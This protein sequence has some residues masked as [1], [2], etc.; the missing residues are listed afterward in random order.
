MTLH[1][2]AGDTWPRLT[3]QADVDLTM[4]SVKFIMYQADAVLNF[5]EVL[6]RPASVVG[7]PAEGKVEYVWKSADT[8]TPGRYFCVF[9]LTLRD[10][11]VLSLP[12]KG[13]LEVRI[14]E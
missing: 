5:T 1:M 9:R 2:K 13:Y 4:G 12:S 3:E 11:R 7:D 8:R 6:A 10:G 14:G